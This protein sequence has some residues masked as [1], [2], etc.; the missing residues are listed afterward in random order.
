M[1]TK[2][3]SLRFA[4]AILICSLLPLTS[5]ASPG[6]LS[7]SPLFLTNPVEPNILF[8]VDDS[9][10]MDWGLMTTESNGIMTLGCGYYYVQPA[11]D[12]ESY[13]VVP[14]EDRKSVV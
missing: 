14:T 4:A 5:H 13:W 10:S 11:P 9:G 2:W 8:I 6:T 7:D 1:Q 12:N 3:I